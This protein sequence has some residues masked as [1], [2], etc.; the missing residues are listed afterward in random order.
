MG[1]GAG[2][3]YTIGSGKCGRTDA[4]R[5]AE[6]SR[7]CENE[8]DMQREAI[9][10][11]ILGVARRIKQCCQVDVYSVSSLT[12]LGLLIGISW[13]GSEVRHNSLGFV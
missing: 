12:E 11:H 3:D 7:F 5:G 8:R 9:A 4:E 2:G 6:E 13:S 10:V 1:G